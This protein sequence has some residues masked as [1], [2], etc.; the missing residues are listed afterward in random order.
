M[1]NITIFLTKVVEWYKTMQK[2]KHFISVDTRSCWYRHHP[3]VL[4][5]H[6]RQVFCVDDTKLCHN[7]RVVQLVHHIWD[8]VEH[9]DLEV[10]MYEYS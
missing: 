10:E 6:V 1:H 2:D 5:N 3:F 7:W 9:E 8:I 4:P